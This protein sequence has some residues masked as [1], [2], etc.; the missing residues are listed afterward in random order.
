MVIEEKNNNNNDEDG[1]LLFGHLRIP[2][3]RQK[4]SKQNKRR[5][6]WN[7]VKSSG[8]LNI[9]AMNYACAMCCANCDWEIPCEVVEK[10]SSWG[11]LPTCGPLPAGMGVSLSIWAESRVLG[12]QGSP[13]ARA[14]WAQHWARADSAQP[15]GPHLPLRAVIYLLWSLFTH[16]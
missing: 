1:R 2:G 3:L 8:R 13:F 7:L 14:R 10:L 9:T 15:G 11:A 4:Q 6:T 16:L 12:R 5:K